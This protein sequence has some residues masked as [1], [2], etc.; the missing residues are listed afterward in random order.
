[1]SVYR[2][3]NMYLII[4]IGRE[5]IWISPN[6]KSPHHISKYQVSTRRAD[7]RQAAWLINLNKSIWSLSSLTNITEL[8]HQ[9]TIME[10][11]YLRVRIVML[12]EIDFVIWPQCYLLTMSIHFTMVLSIRKDRINRTNLS[13]ESVVQLCTHL[14]IVYRHI[15]KRK[16]ITTY[17]IVMDEETTK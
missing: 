4:K 16:I 5:R 10:G 6:P 13:W 14:E 9:P 7:I 12:E 8:S 11:V 15:L 3:H 17:D 2:W 1:M